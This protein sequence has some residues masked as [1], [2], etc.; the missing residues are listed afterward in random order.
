MGNS[1][2][3][4]PFNSSPT[5]MLAAIT[6]A[7]SRGDGSLSSSARRNPHIASVMVMVR[8]ASGIWMRVKRNSPMQVARMSPA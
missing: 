3:I 6:A 7:H 2:A 4:N 8:I 1:A 5:P